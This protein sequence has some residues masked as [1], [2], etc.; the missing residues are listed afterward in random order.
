[1]LVMLQFISYFTNYIIFIYNIR[2]KLHN[3]AHKKSMHKPRHFRK[4]HSTRK[5]RAVRYGGAPE[6]RNK[7]SKELL[8]L[9]AANVDASRRSRLKKE[10]EEEEEARV[11]ARRAQCVKC[12]IEY[13]QQKDEADAVSK[14]MGLPS[15]FPLWSEWTGKNFM[16]LMH[17]PGGHKEY[18]SG[19]A[20]MDCVDCPQMT[21]MRRQKLQ[22][23]A[24]EGKPCIGCGVQGGRRRRSAKKRRLTRRKRRPT[25]RKRRPTR[26]KRH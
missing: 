4:K 3:L 1:M 22:D 21:V 17:G 5:K 7:G 14:Q 9:A 10:K 13:H 15:E 23:L 6:G 8:E 19:A 16:V 24:G 18:G 25:R 12:N 2:M 20:S 11:A 26:R